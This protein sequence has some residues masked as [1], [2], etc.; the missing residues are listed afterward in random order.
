MSGQGQM[1]I[2]PMGP[3]GLSLKYRKALEKGRIQAIRLEFVLEGTRVMALRKG[4]NASIAEDWSPLSDAMA[5]S[6]QGN[7]RSFEE[8]RDHLV[9]KYEVRLDEEAPASFRNASTEADLKAAM[10]AIDFKKRRALQM[11]NREFEISFLRWEDGR[12][13]VRPAEEADK[14]RG[15]SKTAES[16]RA[17]VKGKGKGSFRA[18]PSESAKEKAS[19]S[20]SK[21]TTITSS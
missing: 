13:L 19:P 11:S 17:Q 9:S 12:P 14:M 3:L 16:S 7:E 5:S 18:S 4:G 21:K 1:N 10:A 6:S 2:D 20:S 8:Q 15:A